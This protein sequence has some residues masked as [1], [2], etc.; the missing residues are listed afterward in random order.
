MS[1]QIPA[2]G[3]E[4]L[5]YPGTG[6]TSATGITVHFGKPHVALIA[7][8]LEDG[9]VNLAIFDSSGIPYA[10]QAIFIRDAYELLE[11]DT[12]FAVYRDEP[13]AESV[14]LAAAIASVQS[15]APVQSTDTENFF[16]AMQASATEVAA[17]GGGLGE[18]TL[19]SDVAAQAES[20]AAETAVQ[21]QNSEPL[22]AETN[23]LAD[24]VPETPVATEAAAEPAPEE[25]K[26]E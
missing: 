10:R 24:P 16:T 5:Y 3:D 26:A 25:P 11:N 18:T 13:S 7:G 9:Q 23:P 2:I 21:E 19:Q 8:I 1:K 20:A 22:P 17:P 12:G 14:V 4:V 6:D 15:S